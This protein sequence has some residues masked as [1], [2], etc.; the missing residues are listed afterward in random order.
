M[1]SEGAEKAERYRSGGLVTGVIGIVLVVGVIV[2]GL[3]VENDGLAPWAYPLLL[4]AGVLV[5]AVLIRPAV[6]L[7]PDE[8]ELRNVLHSRW[9]PYPRI[10]AVAI[11]QVTVAHAGDDRYVGSGFGRSRRVLHRDARAL[12]EPDQDVTRAGVSLGGLVED[13]IRRRMDAE[14]FAEPG[15][16][17]RTWAWGEIAALGVL[18]LATLV[19]ALVA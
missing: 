3:V 6:V 13:K 11:T 5:W 9:L 15:P 2:F 10:T 12:Q 14:V 4:L 19:T 8:L 17:R 16:V 1:Q 18:A 7:H